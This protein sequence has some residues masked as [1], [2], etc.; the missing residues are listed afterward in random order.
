MDL[1]TRGCA[2]SWVLAAGPAALQL[3]YILIRLVDRFPEIRFELLF[4][5]CL[6]HF[7]KP[8]LD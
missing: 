7:R 3:L 1:A 5:P 2:T 8:V 4:Q 6:I